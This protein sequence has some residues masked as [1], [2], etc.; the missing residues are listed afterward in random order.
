[1]MGKSEQLFVFDLVQSNPCNQTFKLLRNFP[2]PH[3]F[4]INS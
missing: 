4:R 3:F 1:M 2:F